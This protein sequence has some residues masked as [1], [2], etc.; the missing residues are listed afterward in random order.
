[1]II[2]PV[3]DLGVQNDRKSMPAKTR[4]VIFPHIAESLC[5]IYLFDFPAVIIQTCLLEHA[6]RQKKY[7]EK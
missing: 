2:L 1:M 7:I 4:N 3:N 6:T 5:A